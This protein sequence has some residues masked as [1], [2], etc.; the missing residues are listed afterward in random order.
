MEPDNPLLDEFVLSL[1]RRK[2]PRV[3][4]VPTA[5]A[6]AAATDLGFRWHVG[7]SRRYVVRRDGGSAR[8]PRAR[9]RNHTRG[10][11]SAPPDGIPMAQ[12]QASHLEL[13]HPDAWWGQMTFGLR[14][15]QSPSD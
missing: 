2:R 7:A 4:F 9:S 15:C 8:S 11:A 1:A 14:S 10:R 13:S 5:S 12:S 3:C 6:D